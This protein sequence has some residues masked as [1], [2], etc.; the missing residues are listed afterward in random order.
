MTL[1]TKIMKAHR[2]QKG[3]A[4]L[5]SQCDNRFD[6]YFALRMASLRIELG[7]ITFPE[8]N[9]PFEFPQPL[10]FTGFCNKCHYEGNTFSVTPSGQFTRCPKCKKLHPIRKF[11]VI[12]GE[13]K[14]VL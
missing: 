13:D 8:I 11:R 2:I 1:S 3:V 5:I 10:T 9:Y 6:A 7:S 12:F 14:D 4:E